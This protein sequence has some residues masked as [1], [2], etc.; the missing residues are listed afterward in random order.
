MSHPERNEL[1]VKT[2]AI[3]GTSRA[4]VQAV[5]DCVGVLRPDLDVRGKYDLANAILQFIRGDVKPAN[6]ISGAQVVEMVW[7]NMQCIKPHCPL[8]IFGQ[9]L[10]EELNEFFD[11]K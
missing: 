7:R 8:L 6:L 2:R 1:R 3:A 10:S 4:R 9:Q 11:G 5:W